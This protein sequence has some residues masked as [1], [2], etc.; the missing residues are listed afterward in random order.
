MKRI[1]LCAVA[2]M[3]VVGLNGCKNGVKNEG[4]LPVLDFRADIPDREAVLQD[5][6]KVRYFRLQTPENVLLG[7]QMKL[8]PS[9]AGLFFIGS[10]TGDVI[11]FNKK[12]EMISHFNRKGQGGE[13]Y[14]R[15]RHIL[16]DE[17]R[18]E[19]FL[20]GITQMQVYGLDG[21]YKR[22]FSLPDSLQMDVIESLDENAMVFLDMKGALF[23]KEGETAKIDDNPEASNQPYVLMDKE[24]GKKIERLPI[25]S[26]NRYRSMIVT[27]RDGR[28]FI[29]LNR[30]R[31]LL[32]CGDGGCLISEPAADTLYQLAP[33]RQLKPVFTKLPLSTEKDGKIACEIRALTPNQMLVNAVFLKDEG[34]MKLRD[35]LY[36]YNVAENSFS[37]VKLTNKD[38]Q[39][40][41]M[42]NFVF[43]NNKLYY[44]LYPFTLLEAMEKNELGG[45]LLE[46]TK[47]LD[48]DENLILM[49]VSLD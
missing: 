27:T 24:T 35:E 45:D 39:N 16:Y 25:V 3:L 6:G 43:N 46:I 37:H 44:T 41:D 47:S 10:S 5:L 14:A 20:D 49:E 40:G 26:D 22:S 7:D 29:L 9:E 17:K 42:M 12:G 28:P 1:C 30:M 19:L 8:I 2:V 34:Q 32:S 36:L 18:Q 4:P 38:W 21:T 13:E 33:D 48:E 23:V 11:G 31:N 15:I